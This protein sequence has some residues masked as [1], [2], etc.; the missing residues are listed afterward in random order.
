MKTKHVEVMSGPWKG[1]GGPRVLVEN[2]DF[3]IGYSAQQVL[4]DEGYDVAV[5][6]GPD[7]AQARHCALVATG[8][9]DLA[10]NADVVVHS[11]DLDRSDHAEVLRELRRRFPDTPIVVE[12][13]TSSIVRHQELLNGCSILRFPATRATLTKAV[14]AAVAS[15]THGDLLDQPKRWTQLVTKTE[16]VPT[17]MTHVVGPVTSAERMYAEHKVGHALREA[18]TAPLASLELRMETDPGWP[19]PSLAKVTVDRDGHC[20]RVH[21]DAAT[22][23]VAVDTLVARLR[24]RLDSS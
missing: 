15:R 23:F 17:I 5:C 13:R 1:P 3:G 2:P 16:S 22:M 20:I 10:A 14:E 8:E 18:P 24:D 21:A 19:R 12:V 7:R 6:E 4:M 9:C 11:L